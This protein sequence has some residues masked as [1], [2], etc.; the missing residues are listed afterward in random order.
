M[1][2]QIRFGD[3]SAGAIPAHGY[4]LAGARLFADTSFSEHARR[5]AAP[6]PASL[7]TGEPWLPPA[8]PAAERRTVSG[9]I[10]DRDRKVTCSSYPTG[11]LL[12]IEDIGQVWIA[13]AGSA[14]R[15]MAAER[16]VT[17]FDLEQCVLGPALALALAARGVFMLHAGAVAR[18]GFVHLFLG[19]SGAGKSTLAC[20]LA[21]QQAGRWERVA[22]DILPVT[23]DDG[24]LVAL[25]H[26]PQY[27]LSL[28]QQTHGLPERMPVAACYEIDPAPAG[29]I[30]IR[31][32]SPRDALLRLIRHTVASRLFDS[33]LLRRHL[34]FCAEAIQSVPTRQLS[35]PRRFD[36]VEALERFI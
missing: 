8:E 32:L 28:D 25:P 20:L 2:I 18:D 11:F 3:R 23:L 5:F 27:K 24:R 13:R 4:R 29:E 22:D 34:Q 12:A 31:R 33:A 6:L 14:I 19:V 16:G 9:W 26:Y 36:T 21:T 30:T 10:A 15:L 17:A 1:L 7:E 35:Y